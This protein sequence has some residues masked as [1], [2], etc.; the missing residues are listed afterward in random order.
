MQAV[1]SKGQKS[2]SN[3]FVE[4]ITKIVITNFAKLLPSDDSI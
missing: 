4:N 3:F 1:F 2:H